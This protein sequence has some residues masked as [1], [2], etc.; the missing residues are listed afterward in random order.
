MEPITIILVI[1][2]VVIAIAMF[3][4]LRSKESVSAEVL[5]SNA[6]YAILKGENTEAVKLLKQVVGQDS[7]NINAYLQLG[8]LLRSVNPQQASKIH[9]ALTVR[10]KLGKEI[11][12]EIHQALALDYIELS[13]Y[14]R[15]KIEVDMVLKN[16]KKNLW[17][18]QLFLQIAEKQRDWE[19]A[20]GLASKI[21]KLTGKRDARQLAELQLQ[22]GNDQLDIAEEKKAMQY[23]QNAIKK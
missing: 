4:W 2:I 18:N 21:Q 11:S 14:K 13:D 16:D 5:Y 12:K 9:Q 22:A 3:F 7:D 6:L 10:P 1:A 19:R 8:N 17:A 15:A 23:F 20:S